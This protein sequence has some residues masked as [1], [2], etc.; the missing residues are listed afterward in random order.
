MSRRLL[1]FDIV[2]LVLLVLGAVRLRR[3]AQSFSATHRVDQIQPDSD[4]PVPKTLGLSAPAGK[5]DWPDIAAHDPFSFDRND[6]AIV[7]AATVAQQPKK[8][9]PLLFGTFMLGKDRLALLGPGDGS[10]RLSRPVHAGEVFDGW[11]VAEILEKTVT[12]KW[13]DFKETLIMDDPTAQLARDYSK[14]TAAS[15]PVVSVGSSAAAA[16]SSAAAP[17]PSSPVPEAT[18]TP[19]AGRKQILVPTPFG[20]HL[21]DVP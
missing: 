18:P 9:K 4:K 2:L 17:A 10:T 12:V 3:D 8:P 7:A 19:A 6:V 11:T 1:F 14:T 15:T 5:Q 20:P 21:V 13:D 16:T